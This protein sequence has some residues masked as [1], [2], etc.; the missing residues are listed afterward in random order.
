MAQ[1]LV[2]IAI[3]AVFS[4]K[5]CKN[6]IPQ[7]D[8]VLFACPRLTPLGYASFALWARFLAV[9]NSRVLSSGSL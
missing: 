7:N 2:R 1:S 5:E 6:L 9:I 8:S 3:H 4:T